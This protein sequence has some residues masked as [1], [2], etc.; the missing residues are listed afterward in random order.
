MSGVGRSNL[1]PQQP[2]E[3]AI[4]PR[5]NGPAFGDL[6]THKRSRLPR[7]PRINGPAFT[8]KRSRLFGSIPEDTWP[9]G[10]SPVSTYISNNP[11]LRT[12]PLLG[13]AYKVNNS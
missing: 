4:Y 11:V 7:N 2:V 5:I 1:Y 12:R 9:G 3:T 10:L 6:S 8:H 13:Y